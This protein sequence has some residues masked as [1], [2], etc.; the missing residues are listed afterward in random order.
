M[1]S[2]SIVD[3]LFARAEAQPERLLYRFLPSLSA[4]ALIDYRQA[5]T[6]SSG[7]QLELVPYT[8]WTIFGPWTLDSY[9]SIGLDNGSPDV[10]VGSQLGYTW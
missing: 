4:G 1:S 7:Q 2:R 3:V 8:S 10:G 9:I 6:A 5:P